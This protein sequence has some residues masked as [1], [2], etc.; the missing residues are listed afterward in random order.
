MAHRRVS[1]LIADP[2]AP[3]DTQ[4]YQDTPTHAHTHTHTAL[5]VADDGWRRSAAAVP[6]SGPSAVK[7]TGRPDGIK[8]ARR[9]HTT[10]GSGLAFR[11]GKEGPRDPEKGGGG[12]RTSQRASDRERERERE[13]HGTGVS[14]SWEPA[15]RWQRANRVISSLFPRSSR[16]LPIFDACPPIGRASSSQQWHETLLRASLGPIDRNSP[17]ILLARISQTTPS[18]RGIWATTT[19]TTTKRKISPRRVV[20]KG[21]S[22]VLFHDAELLFWAGQRGPRARRATEKMWPARTGHY[23]AL[24]AGHPIKRKASVR[25]RRAPSDARSTSLHVGHDPLATI[26]AGSLAQI[27]RV[28]RAER[29]ERNIK[30]STHFSPPQSSS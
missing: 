29:C 22:Q 3:A 11:F 30:L 24:D 19:T 27:G 9:R 6:G 26:A 20:V 4:R 12:E 10:I 15:G 18:I 16:V 23:A 17:R 8:L 1:Q 25:K 13:R 21:E 5:T 14:S 2:T 7:K 28:P